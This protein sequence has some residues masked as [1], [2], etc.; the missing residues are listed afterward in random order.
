ML[1]KN[2]HSILTGLSGIFDQSKRGI[3]VVET[4]PFGPMWWT[5]QHHNPEIVTV[6]RLCVSVCVR[7][8]ETQ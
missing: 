6:D 1:T 8:R 3:K 5:D 2:A 4:F 7:R